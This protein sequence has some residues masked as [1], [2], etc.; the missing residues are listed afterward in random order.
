MPAKKQT[1]QKQT[2]HD[3]IKSRLVTH[4]LDQIRSSLGF[5]DLKEGHLADRETIVET[6]AKGKVIF[7][8]TP[9]RIL[10]DDR[11]PEPEPEPEPS[12]LDEAMDEEFEEEEFEEEDL[13]D[14][15]DEE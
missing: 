15:D 8:G 3:Y 7:V 13:E 2:L 10:R 4:T 9:G 1:T 6:D 12:P 14:E 5:S 11:K